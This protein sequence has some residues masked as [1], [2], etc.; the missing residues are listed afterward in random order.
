MQAL[1]ATLD[2]NP[3]TFTAMRGLAPATRDAL[4]R[5]FAEAANRAAGFG[6]AAAPASAAIVGAESSGAPAAAAAAGGVEEP[7][8]IA[9]V[10]RLPR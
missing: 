5:A 3:L 7:A 9:K 2:A 8:A 10:R 6:Q 1:S 4:Y